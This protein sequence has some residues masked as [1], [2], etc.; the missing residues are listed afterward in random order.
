ML[1][2]LKYLLPTEKPVH[3]INYKIECEEPLRQQPKYDKGKLVKVDFFGID[4]ELVVQE[5][6]IDVIEED[7]FIGYDKEISWYNTNNEI[8]H[9]RVMPK[10]MN[11][12]IAFGYLASRRST[13]ISYLQASSVG[14][15]IETYVSVLLSH[16]NKEVQL[17]KTGGTKDFENAIKSEK[18]SLI[19]TYLNIVIDKNG[20]KVK[21]SILKQIT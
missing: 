19:I 3:L 7:Q 1:R 6:Y 13:C 4:D 8:Q 17:F 9:K 18:D 15:P 21:D 2:I 12:A 14:T 10:R 5:N 16:Y 20:N 11:K